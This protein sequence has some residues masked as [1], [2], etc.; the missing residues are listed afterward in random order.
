MS[1]FTLVLGNRN[2]SS[3]SMRA[4]LAMGQAGADFEE[5][6][7]PLDTLPGR[8]AIAQRSPSRKVPVLM[9]G[10]LAIW[11]SLAI[12]EYLAEMFPHAGL[13]PHATAARAIARA[14]C[15]EMHA[16]FGALRSAMPMNIRMSKPDRGRAEGVDADIKRISGIWT[17]LRARFGGQRPY[18]FGEWSAADAFFAPVVSRFSTYAVA[19][20]DTCGAYVDAVLAWPAVAE[21]CAGARAEPWAIEEVDTI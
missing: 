18:L 1:D 16:G 14:V 6:V 17:D 8:F 21:W 3:W 19:L 10:D 13:W 2:Y 9:H 12:V 5:E 4:W 15:A 11:D 20:D 7:I